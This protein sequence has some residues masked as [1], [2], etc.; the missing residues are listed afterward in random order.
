MKVSTIALSTILSLSSLSV[1]AFS[2]D[3]ITVW[4]PGDKGYNGIVEIGKKFTKETGVKIKVEHPDKVE[5]KFPVVAAAGDG[6]DIMI[7]A[8]DRFGGYAEAGLVMD[9]EPSKQFKEKF[10]DFTWRALKYKGKYF[11]YPISAETLSLIYNKDLIS[12]PM[13]N[14]ED[15]FGLNKKLLSKDKKAIMWDIQSPFFSWPLITANGAYSFKSTPNGYDAKNVGVNT[16]AAKK[17]MTFLKKMVDG[18]VI[19][20]A[21][22]YPNSESAFA[23]GQV[24]MTINGPWSWANLDKSGIN[25]GLATLPMLN[26]K[27]SRPFVGVLTAGI[28]NSSPNKDLAKE[29]IE[30]YLLTNEGL[31]N[32]NNHAPIGAPALKSFLQELSSDPRVV[33]T[34]ENARLG[35]VMPNIPQM[36]P[37]WYG[38]QAAIKN[39]LTGRQSID[40]ALSA[41]EGRML[42]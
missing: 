35:E 7:F 23:Q 13:E 40:E 31:R 21:S 36:M 1:Y 22:D 37:F 18:G 2:D 20:A 33:A 16:E 4:I 10:E 6:P 14:W 26:G 24:A 28:N 19:S 11:G 15:V 38:Q 41:V 9:I 29:F 34:I 12:K 42:Q 3:L 39:V 5:E 30:N 25:Y 8:H 32:M 17:S 27:P